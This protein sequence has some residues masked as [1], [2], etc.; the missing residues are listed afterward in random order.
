MALVIESRC[1]MYHILVVDD[2]ENNRFSIRAL[3]E[4]DDV[5]LYEA[6]NGRRALTIIMEKT[7]DLIILDVQLPDYNGFQLAK[8]IKSRISTQHIPVILATAIFKAE[9][10]MEQGFEVGAIDYVLKPINGQLLLPKI[11]YYRS[12]H[13]EKM[14][15]RNIL[16]VCNNVVTIMGKR[17][18]GIV[19]LYDKTLEYTNEQDENQI[20][21][22]DESIL[23][24]I[25]SLT[26]KE[27][28]GQEVY[29]TSVNQENLKIETFYIVQ[30]DLEKVLCFID[31]A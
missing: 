24:D 23:T 10:F 1:T 9:T 15:H 28:K 8:V 26:K 12:I 5:E 17:L 6:D 11:A 27:K 20:L 16:A 25:I 29:T 7:V 4:S 2:N 19:R 30:S 31:K 22:I 18:N 13:E 14:M 21:L 3:L